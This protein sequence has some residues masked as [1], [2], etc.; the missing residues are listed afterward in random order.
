MRALAL[1]GCFVLAGCA[2]TTANLQ[3]DV[4][5]VTAGGLSKLYSLKGLTKIAE[6][7]AENIC[8]ER[9]GTGAEFSRV[10][11]STSGLSGEN[12]ETIKSAIDTAMSS[13]FLNL[14]PVLQYSSVTLHWT[15]K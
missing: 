2:A 9:K 7:E 12:N 10:T 5:E 3:D 13:G 15:C 8:L 6:E 14:A 11:S 1:I 4:I